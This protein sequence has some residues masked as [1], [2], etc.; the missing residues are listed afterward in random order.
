MDEAL[1]CNKW[2]GLDRMDLRVG[3][4]CYIKPNLMK[5]AQNGGSSNH[6]LIMHIAQINTYLLR[7]GWH[8]LTGKSMDMLARKISISEKWLAVSS[9]SI[10][11]L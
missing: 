5:F 3:E 11:A 10:G 6:C 8:I 2:I 1:W 7:G 4:V 9:I